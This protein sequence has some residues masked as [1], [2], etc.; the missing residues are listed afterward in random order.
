MTR[1]TKR[2]GENITYSQERKI[3]CS[4]YCDECSHGTA[5]CK[6]VREMVK[7]LADYE[8]AEGQGLLLR[9]PF[10]VGDIIYYLSEG[11]IEP[12]T[13]ETIF[14]SD[15]TDKD[16]NCSYMAEIH[17]DREDCP[18]VSTEIYFTELG[19]TVFFTKEEAE[20]TLKDMEKGV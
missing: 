11:F 1:L 14:I 8:D 20:Q 13:V 9:L 10:K 5:N 19:K 12:C 6:T 17:Y 2:V 3:E 16:G 7:K 18:Y 4:V 15:Y